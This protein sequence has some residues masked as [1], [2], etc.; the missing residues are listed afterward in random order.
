MIRKNFILLLLLHLAGVLFAQLSI[1]PT[2][3][4]SIP[5]GSNVNLG[6]YFSAAGGTPTKW[7]LDGKEITLN[8]VTL[9]YKDDGKLLQ[10]F[11][12]TGSSNLV[13]IKVIGK[14][15]VTSLT[16]MPGNTLNEGD[17]ITLT[18]EFK[19]NGSTGHTFNGI[20]AA[21]R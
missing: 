9:S 12:G 11:D 2:T 19:A 1:S 16:G 18:L 14:P 4:P 13:P 5:E 7:T 21:K 20:S 3:S 10:C 8:S 15:T 17:Q 6:S